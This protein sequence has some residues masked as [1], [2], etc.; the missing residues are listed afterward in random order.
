MP[1]WVA[2]RIGE[3]LNE[4]GKPVR[5]ASIL[6]LGVTYKADVA[7]V[8]ESPALKVM[9]NLYRR[10]AEVSFHDPY[11]AEVPMNGT[12]LSRVELTHRVMA[13]ADCVALLAPH[14]AYDLDWIAEHAELVFDAHNAFP[15]DARRNV[16]RL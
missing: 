16:V 4:A 11:V 1:R 5:G 13:R 15:E 8:R 3:A 6:V 9:T 12:V 14:G 10:G 2:A 7:D